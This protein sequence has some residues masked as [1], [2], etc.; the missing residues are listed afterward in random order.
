MQRRDT[1]GDT[2]K[3]KIREQ[4]QSLRCREIQQLGQMAANRLD[5]K[6]PDITLHH[7]S[8]I[9]CLSL[10][11]SHYINHMYGQSSP[12]TQSLSQRNDVLK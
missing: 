8:E 3:T 9:I 1:N 5:E 11:K 7:S 10:R 12:I 6:A 2:G 4:T